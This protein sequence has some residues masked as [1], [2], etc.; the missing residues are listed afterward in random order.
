MNFDNK[1]SYS[2]ASLDEVTFLEICRDSDFVSFLERSSDMIT[3]KVKDKIEKY[4]I[5]RVIEF[6]SDRKRMSVI[7][8]N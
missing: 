4:Q 8:K 1:V 2:G 6:T 3:I 7:V 5:L